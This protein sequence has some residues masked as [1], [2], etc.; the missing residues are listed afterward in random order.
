MGFMKK[1]IIKEKDF[2]AAA[3]L[4]E[5]KA[6]YSVWTV[7][8]ADEG[9][10]LFSLLKEPKPYLIC[11]EADWNRDLSPWKAEKVFRGGEDFSGGAESYLAKI[12]EKV[13]PYV[14]DKLNITGC[15][16][17]IAG[18]SLAGLFSLFAFYKTEVFSKGASV[19]GSLWFEGFSEYMEKTPL[20]KVPEKF[21][22]SVGDKE[23]NTKNPLMQSVEDKTK[24]AEEYFSALGIETVFEL[25]N[26]GHFAEPE[27]RMA[28]A[29]SWLIQ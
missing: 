23:K 9:E 13:L 27:S 8:S 3:F 26:G 20:L 11:L 14:E 2:S 10:K 18:Y 29:V 15:N 6:E 24:R 22:F 12:S 7:M 25:N 19:S 16:R 5:G 21:Y 28:K 4:P 1:E 17:I